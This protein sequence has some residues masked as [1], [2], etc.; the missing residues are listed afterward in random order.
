[1]KVI[2]FIIR[3]SN[4]KHS[5]Y[6]NSICSV[7]PSLPNILTSSLITQKLSQLGRGAIIET[8]QM[9]RVS[10]RK[11]DQDLIVTVPTV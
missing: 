11:V 2:T 4:L 9:E 8:L 3:I 7:L 5:G 6:Q 1:M 10:L